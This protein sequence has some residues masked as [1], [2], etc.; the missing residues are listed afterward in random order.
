MIQNVIDNCR[1]ATNISDIK[2]VGYL[3]SKGKYFKITAGS[4]RFGIYINKGTIE[5]LKFGTR[6][7]FYNDFPPY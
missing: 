1:D 7:N 6:E 2:N 3:T 5:F 4:Y